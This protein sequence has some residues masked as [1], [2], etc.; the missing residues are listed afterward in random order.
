MLQGAA[1]V[2]QSTLASVDGAFTL[3]GIVGRRE[4]RVSQPPLGW[5]VMSI[6]AGDRTL[7][8]VPIDFKGDEDLRDVIIVLSDRTTALTGTETDAREIPAGGVSVLVFG[9]DRR[10]LPRRAR[11]VRPD[12]LGRFI[13]DGLPA[14]DYLVALAD[15][16]DDPQWSTAAYLDRFRAQATR[17][18]LADRES[19]PLALRWSPPR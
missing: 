5:S 16:V 14:G 8:D 15:D 19:T 9:D 10:L 3:T 6:T 7:L 17:V 12:T 18:T 11:W 2:G 13:V 4:L 1:Q